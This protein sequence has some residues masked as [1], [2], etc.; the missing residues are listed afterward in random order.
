[1]KELSEAVGFYKLLSAKA[2][3]AKSQ[4]MNNSVAFIR[5]LF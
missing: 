1:M 3:D 5:S 4:S 2:S